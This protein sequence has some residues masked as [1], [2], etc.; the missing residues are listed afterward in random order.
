MA[1]ILVVDDDD[2]MR[3]A[4]REAV[5][6][7]GHEALL[8]EGG[9]AALTLLASNRIDAVLLDLRMTGMDGLEVLGRIREMPSPPAVAVLTAHATADNTIE[10]MRLG[11]FDHLTKPISRSTLT[12]VLETMLAGG[13]MRRSPT[14]LRTG[15]GLIGASESMRAVQKAIGRLADSDS[16]V[17]IT[18]ETG[19]GKELVA[20]AI[21]DHGARG[22]HPFIAV[23][24]AAIPADL[25]ETELF[26]H[27][28]GAF[29]GALR[30]RVGA[31]RE[32]HGGTLSST[33]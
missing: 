32:A 25:M 12:Q 14:P 23:N 18:G 5:I 26:G 33:R 28:K 17:L 27:V 3:D 24:C 29:S 31:F 2:A 16:T 7:L 9:V 6:D 4:L 8:A 11:A 13:G 20:R 30:D 19:T 22:E 1:V 10:A 21:H 15:S